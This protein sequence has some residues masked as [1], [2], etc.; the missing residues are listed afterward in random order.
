[1]WA[2]VLA[3]ARRLN[4]A[5]VRLDVNAPAL[6]EGYHARWDRGQAGPEGVALWRAEVPLLV[7]GQSLGRLEVL[8]VQDHEP[9]W[10]KIAL[11]ARLVEDFEATATVLTDPTPQPA[12][13]NG[14]AGPHVTWPEQ[15]RA[16]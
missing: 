15:V 13:T 16:G 2:S 4:L 11:L 12:L 7:H 3:R 14:R 1:L 9:V 10:Q 6:Q 8:G 5:A